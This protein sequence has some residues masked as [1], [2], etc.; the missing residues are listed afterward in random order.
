MHILYHHR[1]RGRSVE[2][3]HIRSITDALRATGAT[4][5]IMSV[6]GADPYHE[7]IPGAR[8]G[9]VTR[10]LRHVSARVPEPLFEL[11]EV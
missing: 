11:L 9:V 7:E 6:P 2:G 5:D 3:I 4:V 1:T 8:P 10:V